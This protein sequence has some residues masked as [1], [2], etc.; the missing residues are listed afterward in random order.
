VF[1]LEINLAS[2]CFSQSSSQVSDDETSTESRQEGGSAQDPFGKT[3]TPCTFDIKFPCGTQFTFGSL[4][5]ATGE[6]EN[7]KMLPPGPA[8]ER[9]AS[10][11]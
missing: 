10:V 7:L 1:L 8:L 6:D 5:F 3:M 4:M 9:L 11:Y 2:S